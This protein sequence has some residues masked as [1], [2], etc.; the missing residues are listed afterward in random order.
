MKGKKILTIT[1]CVVLSVLLSSCAYTEQLFDPTSTTDKNVE[2]T[3]N[4]ETSV[5]S[6]SCAEGYTVFTCDC[7]DT[8]TGDYTDPTGHDYVS[9]SETAASCLKDGSTTYECKV[10][11]DSYK[12]K[13][14]DALD[15][16]YGEWYVVTEATLTSNGTQAKLCSRCGKKRTISYS[17]EWNETATKSGLTYK[18]NDDGTCSVYVGSCTDSII[19]VPSISPNGKIVTSVASFKNAK[20]SQILLPETITNID[21]GAFNGCAELC[22][23]RIPKSVE[24][25]GRLVAENCPKLKT[26]YFDAEKC[27]HASSGYQSGPFTNSSVETVI[28]GN[29]VTFVTQNLFYGCTTLK[30]ATLGEK[31]TNISANAFVGASSLSEV[32]WNSKLKTIGSSAFNRTA[33]TTLVLP[34]TVEYIGELAFGNIPL[35]CDELVLGEALSELGD[36][37]FMGASRIGKLTVLSKN[38]STKAMGYN[39]APFKDATVESICV[40]DG[41]MKLPEYLFSNIKGLTYADMDGSLSEIGKNLFVNTS[42][43]KRVSLGKNI[44]SIGQAAFSGCAALSEINGFENVRSLGA[45]AFSGCSSLSSVDLSAITS[46]GNYAFSNTGLTSVSF[47]ANFEEIPMNCFAGCSELKTITL[48]STLKKIG[49][50]AFQGSGI[51]SIAIPEGVT[52]MGCYAFRYCKELKSITLPST[53]TVI[54]NSTFEQCS[55]L[56]SIELSEGLESIYRLAFMGCSALTSINLPHTVTSIGDSC[57]YGCTSLTSANIPL[58]ITKVPSFIFNGCTA[59]KSVELHEGITAIGQSAFSETALTEIVL[60]DACK[61]VGNGAFSACRSLATVDFG[62]VVTIENSAFSGCSSLRE[63]ILPDTVTSVGMWSFNNCTSVEK[64]YLGTSIT[65]LDSQA[66]WNC[67]GIKTVYL[68]SSL[69]TMKVESTDTSPFLNCGTVCYTEPETVSSVYYGY[70]GSILGGYTYEEYLAAING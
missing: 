46:I 45:S 68:P 63:I 60:P 38:L 14:A 3:H 56:T 19:K 16:S 47:P 11:G 7:G 53:L 1:L 17:H 36:L 4:Y 39:F 21:S 12:E 69:F 51:E 34:D 31:V 43:L 40:A 44:T 37:A 22:E 28:F 55:S 23:L 59:L 5:V 29:E 18:S 8:Y 26:V 67:T 54:D 13:T 50:S 48:P 66:F 70:F 62:N 65:F 57:F 20:A 24:T 25:I 49:I 42:S 64:L 15:H 2:H 58:S 52:Q 30:K 61:T 41:V 9:I 32:E 35:N 6:P 33:L 10:C 27:V